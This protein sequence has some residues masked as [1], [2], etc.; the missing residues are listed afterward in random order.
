[1]HL[2][3]TSNCELFLLGEE[4]VLFSEAPKRLY[5][6]NTTATFIW[7]GNEEGLDPSSIAAALARRFSVSENVA[8]EDVSRTLAEWKTLGLVDTTSKTIERQPDSSAIS[9]VGPI[10]F[11]CRTPHSPAPCREHDYRLLGL[12]LRIRYPCETT[13]ALIH[14]IFAHLTKPS[15]IDQQHPSLVVDIIN[16]G[17]RYSV[18][19]NGKPV[20][21]CLNR[22]EVAPVIQREALL[23]AY[24][25]SECLVALHAAAVCADGRCV[26]L[27]G[28][29]GSGKSTLTAALIAS[30]L[31][32]ITD[33]MCL[34]MPGKFLIRGAPVS[35]GLKSGS[36]PILA[37]FYDSLE[38]LP[39]FVQAGDVELRYLPPP[40]ENLVQAR[41]YQLR[42]VVFPMQV[43]DSTTSLSPLGAAEALC[44]V[45]EAGYAMHGGLT[46]DRVEALV[47]WIQQIQCYELRL[48]NLSEAVRLIK[49]LLA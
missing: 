41:D 5:R 33:E 8:R 35:L 17:D 6:L 7:C 34:L 38:R 12:N 1:M 45:T 46:R 23:S 22:L 48:G 3:H 39:K 19:G 28:T 40:I 29:K 26:L 20:D 44:R 27:P 9:G 13:E 49:R 21:D 37:S 30:G 47:A 18:L 24:E 16:Q 15:D 36:W 4:G 25:A 14:P 42:C 10:S 43:A 31:G 2:L 32:Y 11:D